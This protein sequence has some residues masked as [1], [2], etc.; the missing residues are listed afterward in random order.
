MRSSTGVDLLAIRAGFRYVIEAW[1]PFA[2]AIFGAWAVGW[3]RADGLLLWPAII[4]V[5]A[6]GFLVQFNVA[7]LPGSESY[8]FT[9]AFAL[10]QR[11]V[12]V[13][14]ICIV[15]L[16]LDRVPNDFLL[17]SVYFGVLM[18]LLTTV[19]TIIVIWLAMLPRFRRAPLKIAI[20]AVTESSV[21]FARQIKNQRFLALELVGFMED[22]T[23]DRIPD[24]SPDP[25]VC[26][27]DEGRKYLEKNPVDHVLIS[28]P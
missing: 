2:V 6:G 15:A 24:H 20:V 9:V 27:M 11:S 19:G 7:S 5:C 23:P 21:S 18:F 10:L 25:I 3:I 12:V 22:R 14:M 26:R 28:L 16:L 1:L 4:G 8:R 13:T 17:T